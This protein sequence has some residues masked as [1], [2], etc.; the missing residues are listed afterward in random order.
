[1]KKIEEK[2]PEEKKPEEKKPEEKTEDGKKDGKK[3]DKVE[4]KEEKREMAMPGD[5]K[6]IRVTLRVPMPISIDMPF[7]IRESALTIGAGRIIEVVTYVKKDEKKSD[8][9][10][11]AGDAKKPAAD[12]KKPAGDAKAP[13]KKIN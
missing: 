11:P 10:K 3:E 2:K 5:R 4:E 7:A 13:P 8:S 12:A 9:K 1:L 6:R